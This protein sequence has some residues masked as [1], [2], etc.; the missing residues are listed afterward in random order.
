MDILIKVKSEKDYKLLS[1]LTRRL[2][3]ASKKLTMADKED[4]GFL[5]AMEEG[6]K[7]G[8]AGTEKVMGKLRKAAGR[9]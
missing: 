3:F 1:E 9:K 2:G 5:L 4:I 7:S 8:I 6:K